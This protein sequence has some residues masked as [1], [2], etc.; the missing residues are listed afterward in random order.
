MVNFTVEQM[1]E[2]MQNR[3]RVRNFS[4]IAHIDH[5][6]STL[7][8]SLLALAGIISKEDAGNKRYMDDREDEIARGITIKSSGVSLCIDS[9]GKQFVFNLIDSPGHVDFSSEVTAALRV[10]DG[11]L[12]V[13]DCVEGVCVQT[14]T[15]LRQAMQEKI[16][17][18]LFLN[19]IDRTIFELELEPEAMYRS[20]RK[21]I[22]SVNIVISTYSG[23]EGTVEELSPVLGTVAFG[24]GKDC[25]GFNLAQFA[26][27]YSEKL[28]LSKEKLL[29][30]FWGD[31]FYDTENK[32]WKAIE[33]ETQITP[34][35]K[36]GFTEFIMKPITEIS[37]AALQND[38]EKITKM[39]TRLDIELTAEDLKETG[40]KL[41][42]A[43]MSKWV[44]AAQ[45]VADMVAGHLPS[46]IEAQKYRYSYLYEGDL[47]DECALAMKNCDPEGP[48]M[49]YVSKM[50]PNPESGK[51]LAFGR[52]FSGTARVGQKVIVMGPHYTP[53]S[54]KDI[55]E[56]NIQ[57]C[58]LIMGK[59]KEQVPDICCGN[60]GALVGLDKLILKNGTVSSS[61]TASTI[62]AMKYSVSPVVRVAI[63]PVNPNDSSKLIEGMRKL[64]KVDNLL[65]CTVNEATGEKI[66]AGSGELHVSICL[67]DLEK[68]YA[69]VPIKRSNPIV[70]Y[71]ETVI[72]EGEECK[73]KSSNK[74]NKLTCKAKPLSEEFVKAF[75]DGTLREEMD[76]SELNKKMIDNYGFDK[77]DTLSM[78]AFCTKEDT[79][80]TFMDSTEGCSYMKEIKDSCVRSFETVCEGGVLMG[81][82]LRGVN[83]ELKDTTIHSDNA[84]RGPSQI[85]PC[86]KKA[87]YGAQLMA[88][89]RICEPYYLLE[90]SCVETHVSGVYS[91]IN[92]RKGKII[93]QICVEGS[94]VQI[95]K[96]YISV[97]KSFEIN[98]DLRQ[99]TSGQAF[100]S[101][102]FD[103]WELVSG[104]PL[105][106]TDNPA[107]QIIAEVRKR[108]GMKPEI[109]TLDE[110]F[111]RF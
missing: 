52:V 44:N 45:C 59:K 4:V 46:P 25:W 11:A 93:D 27:L 99:A 83:F 7:T 2:I 79:V 81:E 8:D 72:G 53:G 87:L 88:Q 91:V 63:E 89:P 14:E 19:K 23:G 56:G 51:F 85:M 96:A 71:R 37:R 90:V 78:W 80:N 47:E 5:G 64:A 9:A 17:P 24:S 49:Y 106:K 98:R 92:A 42:R 75:E 70:P 102:V 73:S 111:D 34:I 18:V 1:R 54:N 50:I 6:K 48:L 38:I 77:K 40:K 35:M 109:P 108:K 57:G 22:E 43:I 84:H 58:E 31:N 36:R 110:F 60:T 66:V 28:K 67:D 62:R 101:L 82:P 69:R 105:A 103:H 26:E 104:D 10:T 3:E 65:V 94:P 68:Y 74:H 97:A 13:V 107:K 29:Q 86:A 20:F 21:S 95:V 41:Y 16:K 76:R 32:C 100:P 12:V 15:V 39:C 55:Y 61:K 30:R 33:D